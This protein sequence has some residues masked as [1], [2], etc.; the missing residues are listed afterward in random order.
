MNSNHFD[1]SRIESPQA[2]LSVSSDSRVRSECLE[3]H[4]RSSFGLHLT[5]LCEDGFPPSLVK[6]NQA[7]HKLKKVSRSSLSCEAQSAVVVDKLEWS[8]VSVVVFFL[9]IGMKG[10]AA[11]VCQKNKQNAAHK[12]M[13]IQTWPQLGN[14]CCRC[15]H[16]KKDNNWCCVRQGRPG[17]RTR[18]QEQA[19]LG[20]PLDGILHNGSRCRAGNCGCWSDILDQRCI[21]HNSQR[22]VGHDGCRNDG[23]GHRSTGT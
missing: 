9:A 22:S 11:V 15:S 23:F 2:E 20:R 10:S 6:Q 3:A 16:G 8:K 13:R 12:T 19:P 17:R 7:L 21:D 14:N 5:G 18:P 1:R 4:L